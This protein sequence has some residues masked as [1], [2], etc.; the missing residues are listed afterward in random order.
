MDKEKIDQLLAPFEQKHK[1]DIE[2]MAAS[3][4]ERIT[5]ERADKERYRDR[6]DSWEA[7]CRALMRA[8]S[9]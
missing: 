1:E 3:Y 4:E 6:A 9:Q 8:L 7:A 5:N 2:R